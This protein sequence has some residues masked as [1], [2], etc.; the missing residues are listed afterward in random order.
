[1]ESVKLLDS[2]SC[3]LQSSSSLIHTENAPR[4]HL[5]MSLLFPYQ[6]QTSFPK[7][8]A[9]ILQEDYQVGEVASLN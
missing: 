1:M 9:D 3:A 7:L 5:L 6:G 2:N 8:F 4:K